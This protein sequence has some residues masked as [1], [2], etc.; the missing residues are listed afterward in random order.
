MTD[1]ERA[2]ILAGEVLTYAALLG[3]FQAI[4]AEAMAEQREKDADYAENF[5]D[6]IDID[7]LLKATKADCMKEILLRYAATIRN[8][9]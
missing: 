6:L 5:V 1:E 9:D 4:R 2:E 7:W 8:Q 3:H